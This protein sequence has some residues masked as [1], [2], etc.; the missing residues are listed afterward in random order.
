MPKPSDVDDAFKKARGCGPL[1]SSPPLPS[2]V[3]DTLSGPGLRDDGSH[4]NLYGRAGGK[5]SGGPTLT[6]VTGLEELDE[7]SDMSSNEL[8][9]W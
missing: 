1:K 9:W 8:R 4:V 6:G 7:S 2:V 5:M 3:P